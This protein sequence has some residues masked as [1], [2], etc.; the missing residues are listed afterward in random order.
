MA[1]ADKKVAF[2]LTRGVEEVELTGPLS[3]VRGA[4]AEAVIVSPWDDGPL[5]ALNSDWHKGE[6]FE[7]DVPV[8]AAKAE[9]YDMLVMPG[10]T[11]NVDNLRT[12]APAVEFVKAFFE[13]GK[14]VAAICH[15]PWMLAE[16]KLAQGRTLTSYHSIKQDLLNAG[17]NWVDQELVRDGNLI[18]SRS[19]DDLEV[20]DKAIIQ[21]LESLG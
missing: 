8:I 18:T 15:A 19:P 12:S 21:E 9:D 11:L 10:G 17:A 7:V 20:F 13:A 4:G 16:A 6:D 1:I 2:L 14:P 3:A 5:T